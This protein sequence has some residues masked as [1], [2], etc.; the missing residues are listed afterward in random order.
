MWFDL[1]P[2]PYVTQ[3][4]LQTECA[5][6]YEQL[7]YPAPKK[8]AN[9]KKDAD[10]NPAALDSEEE[11][12]NLRYNA[13][14]EEALSIGAQAGLA[15]RYQGIERVYMLPEVESALSRAF[16]FNRVVW[17]DNILLPVISEAAESF[18]V[19]DDAQTGRSSQTAL[20]IIQPAQII[21]TTPTW[22][23]Y[24]Y[25]SFQMPTSA[26]SGLMPYDKQE[27][28]LWRTEL[29]AGFQLGVQ[30]A[31]MIFTDRLNHLFRDYSGML[32]F[33]TLAAQ[34]IVSM[35][36]I[37]EGRLGVTQS[38]DDKVYIDDRIIRIDR[39]VKFLN[40]DEWRAIPGQKL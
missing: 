17:E 38:G 26:P 11:F 15:W 31:D 14:K 33:R 12:A 22:R 40:V 13:I 27:Q 39:P 8:I 35:P 1:P 28:T 18:E 16:D 7:I 10:D 4:Q 23:E 5:S 21:T 29:C 20:H 34:K 2:E 37:T 36:E 24:L 3:A 32:R 6:V 25:Q 30:Q 9:T 19:S